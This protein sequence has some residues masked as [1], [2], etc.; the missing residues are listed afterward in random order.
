MRT[1]ASSWPSKLA[2]AGV[3]LGAAAFIV[4]CSNPVASSSANPSPSQAGTGSVSGSTATSY[5]SVVEAVSPSI[6]LIQTAAGL[7]SGIVYDGSG[8]IVTNAHV[9]G[10]ATQFTVTSSNGKQYQGTL[11]GSYPPSDLAVIKA[12]NP[13]GLHPAQFGDSSHLQVGQV[14]LAMGNPLGFQSSVTEGIVS[15][16]GR[17][18]TEPDGAVLTDVVQ[19]S[20]AINPGNSGGGLISL[21][22]QVVGMPTLAAVD[23]QVGSAAPGIGFAL[24]SNTVQEFAGQIIKN[25]KVVN[26]HRAYLGVQVGDVQSP[27]GVVVLAVVAGG[28]AA[29]GGVQVG[30]LITAINGKPVTDS[31]TLSQHLSNLA[32]GSDATLTVNRSGQSMSIKVTLGTLPAP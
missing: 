18:V 15:G 17:T 20:A 23:P 7:G 25:G 32:P 29:Q 28:P 21:Q 9:V 26:T 31:A 5:V 24:S 3:L 2:R 22:N 11:V 19:T 16:L 8:D 13:T 10:D 4:S 12:G 14:V 1:L 30:D 27:P 6:V